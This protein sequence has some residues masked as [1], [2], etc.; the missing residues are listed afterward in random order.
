MSDDDA[1]YVE[2]SEARQRSGLAVR[3]VAFRLG[4]TRRRRQLDAA[5]AIRLRAYLQVLV[6]RAES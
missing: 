5:E 4:L 6:E 2:L 1:F 3:W